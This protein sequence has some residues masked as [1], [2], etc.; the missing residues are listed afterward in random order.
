MI[1]WSHYTST[2]RNPLHPSKLLIINDLVLAERVG[3]APLLTVE[4]KEL[5]GFWLPHDPPDP[6]ETRGGDTYCA[7]ESR[8]TWPV[9][10]RKAVHREP[11]SL[12]TTGP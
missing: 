12:A 9:S 2:R 1:F 3:F 8:S 10:A 11:D 6:L 4:N 5:M 7:R